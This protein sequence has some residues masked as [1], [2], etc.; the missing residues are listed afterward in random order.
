MFVRSQGNHV[1][2]K[3]TPALRLN[4]DKYVL[5]NDGN[6][7]RILFTNDSDARCLRAVRPLLNLAYEQ[8]ASF[9]SL[10]KKH[11]AQSSTTLR[12][13]PSRGRSSYST[14]TVY[15]DEGKKSEI[16][17]P[18]DGC[19]IPEKF[20]ENTGQQEVMLQLASAMDNSNNEGRKILSEMGMPV[21]PD[22]D[23]PI[24]LTMASRPKRSHEDSEPNMST[25]KRI[26][27][28]GGGALGVAQSSVSTSSCSRPVNN[29]LLSLLQA[30]ATPANQ[31]PP[32]SLRVWRPF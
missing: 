13:L 23:R 31:Q 20:G 9:K 10:C 28:G 7:C 24:D 18:L 5:S 16:T 14:T 19:D 22:A 27:V 4:L 21:V 15:H 8:S 26:K 25:S 2:L 1:T 3:S 11:F 30:K 32:T 29:S 17:F 6:L 12:L